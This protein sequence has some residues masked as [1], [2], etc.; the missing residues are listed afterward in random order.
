MNRI[1]E[2]DE[3]DVKILR[4]LIKDARTKLKDIAKQCGLSSVAVCKRVKRL[5]VT[6]VIT[7]AVLFSDMS[8]SGFLYPASIGVELNHS[9]EAQAIHS[10]KDQVNVVFV[11]QGIGKDNLIFFVVAQDLQEIDHLKQTIRK[12]RGIRRITVSH[13]STPYFNFESIDLLPT[14]A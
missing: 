7:G 1:V 6:G 11:S 2:I 4:E 3:I 9:G 10:I 5:K 13:W 14:R 8:R 12:Q